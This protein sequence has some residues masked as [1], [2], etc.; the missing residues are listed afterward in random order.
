MAFFFFTS[1]YFS[2]FFCLNFTRWAGVCIT[3]NDHA[4][5]IEPDLSNDS[6]DKSEKNTNRLTEINMYVIFFS[7][8]HSRRCDFFFAI[9]KIENRFH[10]VFMAFLYNESLKLYAF[11]HFEIF[12]LFTIEVRVVVYFSVCLSLPACIWSKNLFQN[13]LLPYI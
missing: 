1:F 4:V 9:D 6:E 8:L 11:W 5:H 13:D 2:I 7:P 3:R 10:P 12:E